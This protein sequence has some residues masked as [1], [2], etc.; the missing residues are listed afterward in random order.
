MV[1]LLNVFFL[2]K[3]EPLPLGEDL[4]LLTL[5]SVDGIASNLAEVVVS[6][7]GSGLGLNTGLL[8]LILTVEVAAVV[9][10]CC[11]GSGEGLNTGLGLLGNVGTL[12]L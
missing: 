6:G 8:V 10:L 12:L 9:V 11:L 3:G 1:G 5:C 7:L 4:K 2:P